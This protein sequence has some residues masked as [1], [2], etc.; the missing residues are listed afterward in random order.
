MTKNFQKMDSKNLA[1][2]NDQMVLKYHKN[3]TLFESKNPLLR[4]IEKRRLKKIIQVSHLNENDTV[5]DL[6]CGEGFLISF[7]PKLKRIVG[8]DISKIVLKRAKKILKDKSNVQLIWGDAQKLNMADEIFDK[9]ICSETLEH[10][11]YPQKVMK[12][13]HRLLKRNGLA[14]ISVPDEKRIQFIMKMAKFFSLDK[15]LHTA[16]KQKEYDWHL[17]QADKKFIFKN[18]KNLFKMKKIYRTPPLLGYRFIA[19]LKKDE[20]S[21]N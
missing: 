15:L 7:L 6:G 14:I 3:G 20:A 11:P 9:I 18:S 13:I 17:H 10:L 2:W 5:L 1:K 16:R 4:F 12:E 19:V 8:I 21:I